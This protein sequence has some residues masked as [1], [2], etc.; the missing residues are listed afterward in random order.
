MRDYGNYIITECPCGAP[1]RTCRGTWKAQYSC[2]CQERVVVTIPSP[3]TVT[4]VV[5]PYPPPP[6]MVD[7]DPFVFPKTTEFP[8][9]TWSGNFPI[10]ESYCPGSKPDHLN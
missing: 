2:K 7:P 10:N 9:I 3:F 5:A 4:P 1:I 8:N 6:I